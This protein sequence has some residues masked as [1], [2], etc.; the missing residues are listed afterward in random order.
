MAIKRVWHGWTTPE[1][2]DAYWN[3]LNNEVI[4]GIEA[5]EIR[6]YRGIEVLRKDLGEEVEFVTMMTFDSIQS[7]VDFQGEDYERSYVPAPAQGVLK[8]WDDRAAH[9]EILA[10]FPRGDQYSEGS[11]E[12]GGL[13]LRIERHFSVS[14][15]TVFDTL[16]VPEKMRAWWGEDVDFDVDLRVGGEWTIIRREDGVE[17]RATGTYLDVQCPSVL[18]YTFAMPQFSPNSDTITVR[19]AGDDA[20]SSVVFEH[21]GEDIAEELKGLAPGETSATEEGWQQGFDLMEAAWAE[22]SSSEPHGRS[23]GE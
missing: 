19:I 1:N 17:Y 20:G 6:G 9:F 7:V 14:P 12:G 10:A 2:A 8:R 21:T 11:L 5:K 15:E 13:S 3:V 23:G 4:P 22:G 16:T 18:K